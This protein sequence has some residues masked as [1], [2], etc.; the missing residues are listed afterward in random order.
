MKKKNLNI[1]LRLGKSNVAS[2][3]THAIKG[4]TV[5]AAD[6]VAHTIGRPCPFTDTCPYT[7]T[8]P[9][10]N[11]QTVKVDMC[12]T[13]PGISCTPDTCAGTVDKN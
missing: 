8:C 1:K 5:N 4:G 12:F 3:N 11:C 7:E 13:D 6:T 2:F 10:Q 9:Y